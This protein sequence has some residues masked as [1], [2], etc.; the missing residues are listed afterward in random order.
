MGSGYLLRT[1]D[2]ARSVRYTDYLGLPAAWSKAPGLT[3][4]YLDASAGAVKGLD[5]QYLSNQSD[6]MFYFTGLVRVPQLA[7]NHFLPGAAADHL[8]SFGGLLPGGA[9]Q[10]PA[11]DW[12]S[13][14]ATAS[15][16]TVEEPCNYAEKF[17]RASVLIAHY[18]RGATLIEAY[19]KS[20]AWPGQGL[21]VGDPLARP[22]NQASSA[23]IEGGD[24]VLRTRSLRRGSPYRVEWRAAGSSS[25]S[26]LAHLTA[27]QP[28]PITW[29]VALPADSA[30]SLLRWIGPCPTQPGQSC[31]LGTSS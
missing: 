2:A 9:G 10:M 6:V 4:H 31:V 21:F 16:G 29:R 13:A 1:S 23:S 22:W 12:L 3:L 28:Q 26:V 30:G 19:W 11:T 24:L 15:Y 20:V 8:T 18:L 25:W 27:G 17:S 5:A 7:S 14:G